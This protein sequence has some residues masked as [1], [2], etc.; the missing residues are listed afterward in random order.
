MAKISLPIDNRC[1]EVSVRKNLP[2]NVARFEQLMYLALGL[3]VIETILERDRF[4]AQNGGVPLLVS[5]AWYV[6]GFVALCIWQAARERKNWARW[7]LL[8]LFAATLPAS[9]ETGLTL[10]EAILRVAQ[11]F[12]VVAALFLIFSGNARPWFDRSVTQQRS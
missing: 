2:S 12:L 7:V 3:A 1:V 10:T 5:V 11:F 8:I 4:L 9:L 6:Y